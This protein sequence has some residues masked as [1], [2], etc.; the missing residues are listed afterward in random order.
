MNF[1]RSAVKNGCVNVG[2]IELDIKRNLGVQAEAYEGKE[3]YFG[4]RPEAIAL[5]AQEGA[6]VLDG[7]VELTEM[8]G[9]NT[10]VY[11]NFGEY[12]AILKVDPHDTPDMDSH[13]SFSIPVEN[14]YLFDAET[15]EALY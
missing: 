9:D 13:I 12:N 14:A 8:L 2:G 3:V 6:Y 15:E 7:D 5:G 11:V 10:N 1:V 4:F